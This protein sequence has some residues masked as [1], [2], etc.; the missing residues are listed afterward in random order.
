MSRTKVTGQTG[1]Y[2]ETDEEGNITYTPV[3][4]IA[5]REQDLGGYSNPQDA[6]L[7]YDICKLHTAHCYNESWEVGCGREKVVLDTLKLNNKLDFYLDNVAFQNLCD[8]VSAEECPSLIKSGVL[9]DQFQARYRPVLRA[10]SHQRGSAAP[11]HSKREGSPSLAHYNEQKQPVRAQSHSLERQRSEKGRAEAAIAVAGQPEP[12]RERQNDHAAVKQAGHTASG[13]HAKPS[14][15]AAASKAA[16]GVRDEA[17]G[18]EPVD[19]SKGSKEEEK[20]RKARWMPYPSEDGSQ[21]MHTVWISERTAGG[22]SLSIPGSVKDNVFAEVKDGDLI[23]AVNQRSRMEY[24]WRYRDLRKEGESGPPKH[25]LSGAEMKT[26]INETHL[27]CGDVL[28]VVPA[29]PH[30]ASFIIHRSE[31]EFVR[32]FLEYIDSKQSRGEGSGGRKQAGEARGGGKKPPAGPDSTRESSAARGGPSQQPKQQQPELKDKGLQEKAKQREGGQ[33]VAAIEPEQQQQPQELPKVKTHSSGVQKGPL[34]PIA[35]PKSPRPSP[36]A[37]TAGRGQGLAE[38]QVQ[39]QA[40]D[41]PRTKPSRVWAEFPQNSGQYAVE[42]TEG[43]LKTMQITVPVAVWSALLGAQQAESGYVKTVSKADGKGYPMTRHPNPESGGGQLQNLGMLFRNHSVAVGDVVALKPGEQAADGRMVL[44]FQLW[45]E[46]SE[47]AAKFRKLRQ[48]RLRRSKSMPTKPSSEAVPEISGD[49]LKLSPEGSGAPM[50]SAAHGPKRE[51]NAGAGSQQKSGRLP[52]EE[53]KPKQQQQQQQATAQPVRRRPVLEDSSSEDEGVTPHAR[54]AKPKQQ[55]QQ[56]GVQQEAAQQHHAG[57]AG[58]DPSPKRKADGE[59]EAAPATKR[60]EAPP[61][62]GGPEHSPSSPNVPAKPSVGGVSKEA[63]Q[64]QQQQHQHVGRQRSHMVD[65]EHGLGPAHGKRPSPEPD[66]AYLGQHKQQHKQNVPQ[67]SEP[68]TASA[69]ALPD[70][71]HLPPKKRMMLMAQQS[72][73]VQQLGAGLS[74]AQSTGAVARAAAEGAGDS[75]GDSVRRRGTAGGLSQNRQQQHQQEQHRQGES[76]P[77][78]AASRG[79]VPAGGDLSPRAPRVSVQAGGGY[80]TE[81]TVGYTGRDPSAPDDNGL[82]TPTSPLVQKNASPVEQP[83]LQVQHQGGR[84]TSPV[85]YSSGTAGDRSQLRN[86]GSYT[87]A[88]LDRAGGAGAGTSQGIERRDTQGTSRE[89]GIDRHQGSRFQGAPAVHQPCHLQ[90]QQQP[91]QQ[92]CSGAVVPAPSG[93]AAM[94]SAG[95]GPELPDAHLIRNDETAVLQEVMRLID[96]T[97]AAGKVTPELAADLKFGLGMQ[98]P[99]QRWLTYSALKPLYDHASWDKLVEML[100]RAAKA[101]GS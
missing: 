14:S 58:E 50:P 44:K 96:L 27:K 31:T 89:V 76:L 99:L 36:F 73:G 46:A 16:S 12:D 74:G 34:S 15:A 24:K 48:E 64:Q 100:K 68:A 41:K 49:K 78:A 2:E 28:Q 39:K 94:G 56:R 79:V 26:F 9:L 19:K 1:I 45:K 51:S 37:A 38:H 35:S 85:A 40:A 98:P 43:V 33:G 25:Y 62:H 90:P 97:M 91:Q 80:R 10:K 23:T 72:L 71:S 17:G 3:L 52:A 93:S 69:P 53:P 55:L 82:P 87:A 81:D 11:S 101:G 61:A 65:V 8:N 77:Q 4:K 75:Q 30:R 95:Q 63:V 67:S 66:T 29:G 59:V 42:V 84:Q 22:N 60:R 86:M 18:S 7:A 83:L 47:D 92:E 13:K 54:Q 70:L 21:E 6:A 32:R 20:K 5:G 57:A 88:P